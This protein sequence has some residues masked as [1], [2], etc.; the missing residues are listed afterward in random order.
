MEHQQL[1]GEKVDN[2]PPLCPKA[3]VWFIT[4]ILSVLSL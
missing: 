1:K 3:N 4:Q 2:S